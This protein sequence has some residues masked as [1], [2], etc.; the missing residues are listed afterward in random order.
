MT[1]F[2][3]STGSP[4]RSVACPPA[5]APRP[6]L[7]WAAVI[8][9]LLGWLLSFHAFRI[10]A[11]MVVHDALLSRVC[12][13]GADGTDD[14]TSVLTSP[15]AYVPLGTHPGS[16][17]LPTSA[18]GMAYFAF[19]GLWYLFVGPTTRGGRPWHTVPLLLVLAGAAFSTYAIYVMAAILHRWCVSC[20]AAHTVNALLILVTLA[21]WPS[22]RR[23][24]AALP[25]PG[26]RLALATLTA[27][28]LAVVLHGAV[29]AVGFAVTNYNVFR[30]EAAAFLEDPEFIRWNHERQ[31]PVNLPLYPDEV[32]GGDP[33][34]PHTLV[35]FS[36]FQCRACRLS[37]EAIVAAAGRHGGQLRVA[38]RYFPQDPA[39]NEEPSFR[40]S[41]H[42]SACRA[43]LAAEA[44]RLVGGR[45]AYLAM[46]S[47]LWERQNELPQVPLA[48]QTPAQRNL[49][50]DWAVELGLSRE[51]FRAALEGP[52]AAAR[53][54][55]D[56]ELA[57]SLDIR[58]VPVLFLDGKKVLNA[59]R[60]QTWDVLLGTPTTAAPATSP[61]AEAVP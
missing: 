10:S 11:G 50:E 31:A 25:H 12:G 60:S 57:R 44:A 2:D 9:A 30:K 17:R 48:Q 41:P 61:A 35:T 52:E 26:T 40:S 36:D 38:F 56:I 55:A 34:A 6:V 15:Q 4:A 24:V 16:P 47:L 28:L 42:H 51:A 32:F 59:A 3:S 18:L 21:A 19:L 58:A 27:G 14:C 43:A 22:R 1:T 29:M 7:R 13:P 20:L 45:D 8:L 37:H 53:L 39:C 5:V 46:R 49:F 54:R 23:D 33:D